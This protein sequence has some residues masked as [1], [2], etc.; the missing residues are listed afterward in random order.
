[1]NQVVRLTTFVRSKTFL[2]LLGHEGLNKLLAGYDDKTIYAVCT[3]AYCAG[4]GQEPILFRGRTRGK[5]VS[6]R[7]PNDFGW[8]PVFEYEELGKTYAEMTKAEKVSQNLC[9]TIP[10]LLLP[11]ISCRSAT[12]SMITIH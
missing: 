5:L 4:P 2:S 1:M 11:A 9:S 7:G 10:I 6:A 3:F 12:S 8:D